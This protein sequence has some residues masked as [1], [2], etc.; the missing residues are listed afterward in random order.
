MRDAIELPRLHRPDVSDFRRRFEHRR[1]PA[2]LTGIM[3]S[4]P[5]MTRWSPAY[6]A[7]HLADQ[8]MTVSTS[9]EDLPQDGPISPALLLKMKVSKMRMGDYL[10]RMDA[11]DRRFY[12]SGVPLRPFLPML[13]DDIEVPEYREVGSNGSPRMW[14]GNAQIGPLHYDATANLHGIVFGS[15]R[16]TLFPPRQLPLLY[17]CSMFSKIPTMSQASL[18]SPDYARFPRLRNAKPVIV[19]LGPGDMLF[20]P[21]GWW[22]QVDTPTPTISI[23][24]PGEKTP[25]LGRPFVRLIP[26]KVLRKVR[27]RLG[28]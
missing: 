1:L 27:G 2:V 6:F 16:F 23:D 14:M 7:E 21:P 13:L 26:W 18:S 10:A 25:E 24:F 28:R 4:W 8:L 3:D 22:H 11:R 19:D 20:L 17:P 5:A 9:D 15:K 12:A